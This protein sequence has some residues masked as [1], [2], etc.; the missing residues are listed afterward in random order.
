MTKAIVISSGHGQYV[1]GAKGFL[2]E[3]VEARRIVDAVAKYLREHGATVYVYHDNTSRTQRDNLNAIVAYHNGKQRSL[4]VSVHLN[5]ASTTNDPR[6]C[7]VLYYDAKQSAINVSKAMAVAGCFKD[8]GA[9]ERRELAFLAGTKEKALLLETGFVDSRA[10]ADLYRRN[11][12]AICVAIAVSLAKEAGITLSMPS[13][14]APK[15]EIEKGSDIM[16]FTIIETKDAVRD[17]LK[18]A[19]DSKKIDKSWLDKFDAGTL[20]S[21]DFEGLKIIISQR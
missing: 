8:R 12:D 3:V 13:Q 15:D 7:E 20:T 14:P 19:V 16:Q 2:D 18:Q 6:G 1:R 9:K 21:G 11:F 17:L 5:A 10:D 4:D